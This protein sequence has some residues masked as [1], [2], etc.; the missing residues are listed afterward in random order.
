MVENIDDLGSL[1]IKRLKSICEEEGI[2][3][4]DAD[5]KAQL[6]A[7][8]RN[9]RDQELGAVSRLAEGSKGKRLYDDPPDPV[10][11]DREEWNEYWEQR[12]E[13]YQKYRRQKKRREEEATLS[14]YFQYV[15]EEDDA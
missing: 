14:K 8:I 15:D 10:F 5:G 12:W 6:I 11:S 7:K 2:R 1:T 13:D 9:E 3:I 4:S